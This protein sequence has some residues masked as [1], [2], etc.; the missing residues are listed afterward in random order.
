M[1][2]EC[3]PTVQQCCVSNQVAEML[4]QRHSYLMACLRAVKAYYERTRVRGDRDIAHRR[5]VADLIW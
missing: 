4:A 2:F 3:P 1:L 5:R